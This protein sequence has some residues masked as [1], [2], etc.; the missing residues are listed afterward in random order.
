[1]CLKL[2]KDKLYHL[3]VGKAFNKS[4]ISRAKESRDFQIFKDYAF[5][6]IN[7]A[8]LLYVNH[9]QI[10]VKYKGNIYALDSTTIDMCLDVFWWAKFRTT[11]AAFKL[12]TLLDH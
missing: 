1:M 7:Q 8:K 4:T 6:P 3:G 9:N 2:R 10:D 5:S 11:K 12:H